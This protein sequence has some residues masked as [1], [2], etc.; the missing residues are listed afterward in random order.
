MTRRDFYDVSVSGKDWKQYRKSASEEDLFLLGIGSKFRMYSTVWTS[1][2]WMIGM[3]VSLIVGI[4][5]INSA[6]T[7]D[8]SDGI[9][10]LCV[11]YV[12]FAFL[13]TKRIRYYDTLSSIEGALSK[14][15]RKVLDEILNRKFF[16]RF[17]SAL[18]TLVIYILTI[19]YQFLML[20]VGMIAP[21]FVVS[22]NGTLIT[23]PKGC[24]VDDLAGVAAYYSSQSLFEELEQ[25]SY[26]KNHKYE[27]E[28]LD[29]YGNTISV[30]S[31]DGI[32]FYDNGGTRYR[33]DGDKI[34]KD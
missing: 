4:V 24:D 26:E 6:D 16:I 21:K 32:T 34:I 11:G 13:C 5:L 19:P 33:K 27:G 12:F 17:M 30:H 2:I 7:G 22:K 10:V 1:F 29:N 3:I 14:E 20:A 25:R 8:I 31:A 18:C 15:N 23:I 28:F 9:I